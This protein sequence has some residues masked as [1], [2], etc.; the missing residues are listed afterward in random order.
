MRI[1]VLKF[2]KRFTD[3]WKQNEKKNHVT[4]IIIPRFNY[5][6]KP[7]AFVIL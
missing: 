7:I 6:T 1:V 5:R 3:D 2:V 4:R